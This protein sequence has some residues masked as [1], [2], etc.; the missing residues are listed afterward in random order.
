MTRAVVAGDRLRLRIAQRVLQDE[1]SALRVVA[2]RLDKDF[3]QLVNGLAATPGRIIVTGIG[4][5][6]DVA[7]KMVATFNSTGTRSLF[8]DA[9][10]ALHG[11]LGAMAD[12]DALLFLSHSGE[13]VELLRLLDAV[14][15][16]GRTTFAITS[17]KESTLARRVEV[18]FAYGPVSE[19]DPLGLAPSSSTT[20]M[21]ALGDAI[22]FTLA[23]ERGFTARDF[24]H[25]HPAGNLG[26]RLTPVSAVMRRGDD[27][28]LAPVDGSIRE[29]LVRAARPGRR[30][31]AILLVDTEGRLRGLFTDS[32]LARLVEQ[33]VDVA[34][35]PIREAMSADPITI[36]GHANLAEALSVLS[37]Y[38]IS[39]LPV[40]DDLGRPVGLIDI[41]DVVGFSGATAQS[42]RHAA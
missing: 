14:G 25:F 19:A 22:A 38:K 21:M 24:A 8:L 2:D 39:E 41:T 32:D 4:K 42:S 33:G 7:R 11:D 6:A 5:S 37:Q 18:Y 3:L 10:A 23:H 16:V 34:T 27:L 26:M 17:R 20:V 1:A 28:R 30:S 35:C 36:S 29:A 9:S 12:D 15:F 13:S 31:G 40:I